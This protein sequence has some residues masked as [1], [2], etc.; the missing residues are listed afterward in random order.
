M[1]GSAITGQFTKEY[2]ELFLRIAINAN[3]D[4]QY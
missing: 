4:E 3:S 2:A 1:K